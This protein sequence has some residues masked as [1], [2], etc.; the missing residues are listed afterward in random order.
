MHND[1]LLHGGQSITFWPY[2]IVIKFNRRPYNTDL[3]SWGFLFLS[4]LPCSPSVC[5]FYLHYKLGGEFVSMGEDAI[6]LH[7]PN[8]PSFPL[9]RNGSVKPALQFCLNYTATK[10]ER[11]LMETTSHMK[12]N[13]WVIQWQWYWSENETISEVKWTGEP[14]M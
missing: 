12:L 13:E 11:Y 1:F 6:V 14:M 10:Q 4:K 8:R 5:V 3:I 7:V 2:R 9:V